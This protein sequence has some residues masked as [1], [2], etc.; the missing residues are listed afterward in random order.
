M[1]SI[2]YE[3]GK[4]FKHIEEDTFQDGC[5]EHTGQIQDAGASFSTNTLCELADT[6]AQYYGVPPEHMAL[7]ACDEHGRLDI[8]RLENEHGVQASAEEVR[9]WKEG[10][11]RLWA[12]TYTYHIKKVTRET[13]TI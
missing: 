2:K 8:S 3:S 13:V 1:K 5:I 9:Q 6:I 7:N 11:Q 10:C 12:C 4:G